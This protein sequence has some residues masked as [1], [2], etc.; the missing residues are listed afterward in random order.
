MYCTHTHTHTRTHTQIHRHTCAPGTPV[1]PTHLDTPHMRAWQTIAYT[2]RQDALAM[3]PFM[4]VC[5]Y[6]CVC[7][8]VMP[9]QVPVAL[10]Y[11]FLMG[12]AGLS[13]LCESIGYKL[14]EG[15]MRVSVLYRATAYRNA[16]GVPSCRGLV[17]THTACRI[18]VHR[19]HGV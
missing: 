2:C 4:H 17:Y 16:D 10:C 12:L 15:E 8:C 9:L 18:L 11:P 3:L 14:L 6:T 7:V 5:V 1:P 19:R 13:L